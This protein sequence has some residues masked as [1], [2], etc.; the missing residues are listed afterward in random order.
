MDEFEDIRDNPFLEPLQ[1]SSP[2]KTSKKKNYLKAFIRLARKHKIKISKKNIVNKIK[3]NKTPASVI[4]VA[5]VSIFSFSITYLI[6]KNLNNNSEDSS[7]VVTKLEKGN[8][9]YN[10][11]TPKS[12]NIDDLGGWTKVSP[13]GTEPVYAYIDTID[14]I[15]ITVSQQPLPD[16]LKEDTAKKIESLA[17]DFNADDKI[18]SSNITFYI[19][20]STSGYQSVI[21]TKNNLLILIKSTDKISNDDWLSYIESLK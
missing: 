2:I 5:I 1:D 11:I 4:I 19:S 15:N 8:P 16:D 14:L 3:K 9:E 13:T 12:K 7:L 18:T 20:N 17:K 6:N 10:T 21:F